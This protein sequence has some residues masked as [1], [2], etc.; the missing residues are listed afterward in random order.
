MLSP[1]F[2]ILGSSHSKTGSLPVPCCIKHYIQ[3]VFGHCYPRVFTTTRTFDAF[4]FISTGKKYRTVQSLHSH[5]IRTLGITD[6][7]S[8]FTYTLCRVIFS[9]VEHN[10]LSVF[11]GGS[12]IED[13][14]LLPLHL[15]FSHRAMKRGRLWYQYRVNPL[16]T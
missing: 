3:S 6:T 4:K 13:I 8:S 14:T 11:H 1:V 12:R 5:S 10:N 16:K 15:F 7:G 2:Q 9:T